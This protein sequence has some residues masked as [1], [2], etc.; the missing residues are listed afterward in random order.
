MNAQTN[1]RQLEIDAIKHSVNIKYKAFEAV[2]SQLTKLIEAAGG[3]EVDPIEAKLHALEKSNAEL[4]A[5][6]R[7]AQGFWLRLQG[8]VVTLSEKRAEQL[9]S[10]QLARKRKFPQQ[11]KANTL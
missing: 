7:D 9:N 10:L 4:D 11:A 1:A 8:H 3:N 6:I 5:E 2:N